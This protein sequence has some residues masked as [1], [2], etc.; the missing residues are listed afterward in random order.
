[1]T[2]SRDKILSIIDQTAKKTEAARS[3]KK[4]KQK[5][6][7][8]LTIWNDAILDCYEDRSMCASPTTANMS[9][10]YRA[11]IN[12]T[13][14]AGDHRGFIEW[15]VKNWKTIGS[16]SF[17]K[18]KYPSFPALAFFVKAI[19]TFYFLYC[20]KDRDEVSSADS[21][22]QT[23]RLRQ[24][25]KNLQKANKELTT[26]NAALEAEL[27]QIKIRKNAARKNTEAIPKWE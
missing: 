13:A 9:M 15:V 25:I 18:S 17:G 1:M 14:V 10:I 20:R 23:K 12:K 21:E 8:Y 11:V 19:D 6:S 24:E 3:R 4:S 22:N 5:A 27:R 7:S 26:K 16:R 2:N